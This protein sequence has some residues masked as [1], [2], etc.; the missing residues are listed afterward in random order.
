MK[1]KTSLL[2]AAAFA[3]FA[4][5]AGTAGAADLT[6]SLWGGGYGERFT[7]NY[8]KP[9]EEAHGVEIAID[10]GRSSERLSKLIATK[11]RGVDLIF[12][13]DFQMYEAYSRNLISNVTVENVPNRANLR[14]FAKDPMGGDSCPA[15]VVLGAGLAYNTDEFGDTPPTS[16]SD[17]LRD[18]LAGKAG[19]P[20]IGISYATL[21]A[22]QMSELNG[23]DITNI[24]A[25]FDALHASRDNLQFF[26]SREVLESVVRGDVS[27]APQL[28]I[29]VKKEDGV[30][31]DF[32]WPDEG[33]L[34]V[35]NLMCAVQGSK[36]TELA[37]KFMNYMLSD[38]VQNRLLNESGETP[39]SANVDMSG[40]AEMPRNV[41]TLEEMD[42]LNFWDMKTIAESKADW[43]ELWQETVIAN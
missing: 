3:A 8:V 1:C 33:G 19:Y 34:G 37:E 21:L 35:L 16:W 27:L 41:L 2:S 7:N 43:V 11:G 28:N 38:E 29:F 12:L 26:A 32:A 39:V 20:D 25:G 10:G 36:N 18:D 4:L 14:D 22:I 42:N 5:T 13:S 17:I 24:A 15:F 30:P 23:G 40:A 9:F 6:I 31:M